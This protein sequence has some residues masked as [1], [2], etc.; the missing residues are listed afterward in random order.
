VAVATSEPRLGALLRAHAWKELFWHRRADVQKHMRFYL[1]GHGLGE[2][3]LKP[4]VG[5]TGRGLVCEVTDDFMMLPLASQLEAI[6]AQ[7][8]ARAG[9]AGGGLAARDLTP[10]PLL[11]IPGWCVDNEDEHYYDNTDYFRPLVPEG[12][13][14][15]ARVSRR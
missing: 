5:V 4:F 6:D 14:R 8:A 12:T 11:G 9:P 13:R 1:F 7:I 10:V 15:P 2:K 3:M